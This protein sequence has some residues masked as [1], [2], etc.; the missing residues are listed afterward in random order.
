MKARWFLLPVL[1][2]A[3]VLFSSCAA[4]HQTADSNSDA[5][6]SG[7]ETYVQ[8]LRSTR[9]DIFGGVYYEGSTMHVLLT[10]DP[11][12]VALPPAS[13]DFPLEVRQVEYTEALLHAVQESLEESLEDYIISLGQASG[14]NYMCFGV[15]ENRVKLSYDP[16]SAFDIAPVKQLVEERFGTAD[17][18]LFVEEPPT[19][20][21]SGV[22]LLSGS[23]SANVLL[24]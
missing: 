18:M 4:I 9:P 13:S 23:A 10:C 20:A 14:I 17:M 16:D 12:S 21:I 6:P 19:E 1:C 24:H 15:V 8:E 3:L 22:G 11:A 5:Y 2:L 7:R